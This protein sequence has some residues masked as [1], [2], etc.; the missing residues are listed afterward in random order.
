MGLV[1]PAVA[2]ALIAFYIWL[3][4]RIVNRRERWAKRTAL[5]LGV[6]LIGYPLSIGPAGWLLN[7]DGTP[8]RFQLAALAFYKPLRLAVSNAPRPARI[9]AD[10]YCDLWIGEPGWGVTDSDSN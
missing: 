8:F 1:L 3:T 7:R 2:V 4:V 10:Q 9:A 6:L 5:I